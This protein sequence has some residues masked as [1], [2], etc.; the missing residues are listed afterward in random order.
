MGNRLKAK[1]ISMGT[2][3]L[4]LET[5]HLMD[6]VDTCYVPTISRNLVS[7]SRIGELGYCLSF[8]SS[9]LSIFYDSI[10]VGSGILCD[11][12]DTLEVYINE[13]ER[14]LDRKVKIVRS[15]IGGEFYGRYDGYGQNIGPFARFLEQRGICAQYALPGVP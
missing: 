5:G 4:R 9:T 8:G 6:L 7:L 14:Q 1:V 10:K 3:R 13:V 11:A 15:D 12:I 2:Y